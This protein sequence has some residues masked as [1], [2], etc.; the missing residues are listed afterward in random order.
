MKKKREKILTSVSGK[1]ALLSDLFV[2]L[3][4][5][6]EDEL[7][8]ISRNTFFTF[9]LVKNPKSDQICHSLLIFVQKRRI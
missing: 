4:D 8:D 5:V 1:I 9:I 2:L 7:E 6:A 3:A